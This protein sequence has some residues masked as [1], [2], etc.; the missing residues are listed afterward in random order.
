MMLSMSLFV[1]IVS[2]DATAAGAAAGY[3]HLEA[4][5]TV[6]PESISSIDDEVVVTLRIKGIGGKVEDLPPD[7]LENMPRKP[8]DVVLVLDKSGSMESTDYPPDRITAAKEAAKIFVNQIKEDDRVAVVSFAESTSTVVSFTSDKDSAKSKIGGI[9][10]GGGTAVGEGIITALDVLENGRDESVKAIVLLSDGANNRGISPITAANRAKDRGIPIYTVGI[11]TVGGG[12]DPLDEQTLKEI[13][14]ITGG[15]Y[16]YAPDEAELKR[17]YEILSTKV[18]NVAG[19]NVWISVEPTQFFNI[20]KR[21]P[22]PLRFENIPPDTEKAVEITGKLTITA[23]NERIPV[24]HKYSISYLDVIGKYKTIIGGPIYVE[25]NVETVPSDVEIKNIKFKGE[26]E[27]YKNVKSADGSHEDAT[28]YHLSNDIKVQVDIKNP[29]EVTVKSTASLCEGV[30]MRTSTD[31]KETDKDSIKHTLN[32]GGVIGSY[33]FSDSLFYPED[34]R[35]DYKG[36]TTYVVFDDEDDVDDKWSDSTK[37]KNR[38]RRK[39]VSIHPKSKDILELTTDW[40]SGS[41]LRAEAATKI[42]DCLYYYIEYTK[43]KKIGRD[44]DSDYT[45]LDLNGENRK[46]G[47][48][49]KPTGTCADYAVAYTSCLR[50]VNNP[51]RGISLSFEEDKKPAGHAFT[52]VYDNEW[53][54]TDPT[55][56]RYNVPDDYLVSG[57]RKIEGFVEE[58]PGKKSNDKL[59]TIKYAVGMIFP[60]ITTWG[61]IDLNKGKQIKQIILFR[62]RAKSTDDWWLPDLIDPE[63]YIAEDFDIK[64]DIDDEFSDKLEAKITDLDDDDTLDINE[65]DYCILTIKVLDEYAK[66]IKEGTSENVP[67]PLKVKYKTI[68]GEKVEKEYTFYV[69][70]KR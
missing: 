59:T 4:E 15:E 65:L 25:Y 45:I 39:P 29:E 32:N 41:C 16:L 40:C 43:E 22:S 13:A 49:G 48:T 46:A 10:T 19:T 3:P 57:F 8:L 14:S 42:L 23:P 53:I 58:K 11:G 62:N 17:V 50:S 55:W 1:G 24:I 51:V 69:D 37:A 27:S 21:E 6:N 28:V 26:D 18:L 68:D 47:E 5:Y 54:H 70:V 44:W 2:E 52:E 7:I 63:D 64:V 67:I 61:E 38:N 12:I 66:T 56:N 60:V 20:L 34:V 36:D 35:T 33:I 9:S 30:S 31:S